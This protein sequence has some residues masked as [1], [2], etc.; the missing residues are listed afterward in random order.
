VVTPTGTEP[1]VDDVRDALESV[2][3][4]H[5]PASLSQMGMLSD[6][7]VRE[8][9]RVRVGVRIPC[10]ACPGVG[11]LRKRLEDTLGAVPG[12]TAVEMV[13]DWA[14]QWDRTLVAPETRDLMATHGIRL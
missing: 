7:E 11:L 4:P 8:D 1:S 14:D 6:V 13:E 3:D 5:I 9:G 2:H 10:M 12:V